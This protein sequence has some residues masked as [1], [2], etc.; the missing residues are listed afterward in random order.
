MW[1]RMQMISK[2]E[3]VAQPPARLDG[4]HL[5]DNGN[6][7]ADGGHLLLGS[8]GAADAAATDRAKKHED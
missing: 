5:G 6:R 2:I 7:V 4:S 1:C 3:G 8:L